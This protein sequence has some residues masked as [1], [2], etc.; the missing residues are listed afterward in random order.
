MCV[1]RLISRR[2]K[3]PGGGWRFLYTACTIVQ[4]SFGANR[5]DGR[6]VAGGARIE[7]AEFNDNRPQS[8]NQSTRTSDAT[9]RKG[10]AVRRR[11]E[12]SFRI[13]FPV[14]S[15]GSVAPFPHMKSFQKVCVGRVFFLL[16]GKLSRSAG[17]NLESLLLIVVPVEWFNWNGVHVISLNG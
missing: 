5:V 17:R 14:G 3:R 11:P 9:G 2:R 8:Y 15:T 16:P 6:A 4:V 10:G 7:A 12:R 13:P 1:L